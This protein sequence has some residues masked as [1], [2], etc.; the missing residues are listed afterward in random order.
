M[1]DDLGR[2]KELGRGREA[3][4]APLRDARGLER[5]ERLFERRCLA[6]RR[7]ERGD[8]R[9]Q[10]SGRGEP[11]KIAGPGAL[12]EFVAALRNEHGN[13]RVAGNREPE[14]PRQNDLAGRRVEE[15]RPAHDLRDLLGR[16]VGHHGELVGVRS[17]RRLAADHEIADLRKHI[18]RK[19]AED[20]IVEIDD[21]LGHV[22]S[23]RSNLLVGNLST[24]AG[25]RIARFRSGERRRGGARDLLARA[26][27][28]VN[29]P[30]LA[31]PLEKPVVAADPLRLVNDRTVRLQTRFL[32][33][34]KLLPGA[35]GQDAWRI[36][37]FDADEPFASRAPGEKIGSD[38]R[39]ERPEME[40]ARR[41]RRETSALYFFP[42]PRTSFFTRLAISSSVRTLP[43]GGMS[44]SVPFVTASINCASVFNWNSGSVKF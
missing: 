11:R 39:E 23:P 1:H 14:A 13:M 33:K 3:H 35:A 36:E 43:N 17:L 40:R 44:F 38:R 28:G 31:Q 2:E 30:R 15:V 22:E 42:N 12:G 10:L 24:A 19:V 21:S 27:A 8:D 18:L 37:I 32:E 16:V 41:C 20:L 9:G 26:A 6:E 25:P 29:R 34:R 7:Q 5:R 4:L